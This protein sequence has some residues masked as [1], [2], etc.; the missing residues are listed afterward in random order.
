MSSHMHIG[1]AA[2]VPGQIVYGQFDAVPLPTGGYDS[3]PV[4]IAQGKSEGPTFW[5]TGS[6]HGNE[7]S[8]L[9]V[10][11]R[12]LGPG[13]TDFPLADLRGTV[14]LIPTLNPAGLRAAARAPHYNRGIDPNRTFP[15]VKSPNG[16]THNQEG[17]PAALEAAYA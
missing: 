8:G 16:D 4:I 11:H 14:V 12:L 1:T 7:H 2:S 15:A 17:P 6:I 3:F 13:G 5:I 9:A 10:I